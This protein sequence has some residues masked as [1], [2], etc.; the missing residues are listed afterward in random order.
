MF[1]NLLIIDVAKDKHD[2]FALNSDGEI[3]IE[4]IT[5]QNNLDCFNSL[6]Y[7][8]S[9]FNE[10]LENIKVGIET[11]GHYSNNILNFLTSK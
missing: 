2:C 9:H 6:F 4:R 8:I 7:S 11:T 1:I 3:L 5:I 10:S